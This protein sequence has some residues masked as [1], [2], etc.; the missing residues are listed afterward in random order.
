MEKKL[1]AEIASMMH[2][3]E[4]CEASSNKE[5]YQRHTE[6][7]ETIERS[8]LP[9]GSGIDNGCTID[10]GRSKQNRIVL[11]LGFHHMNEHGYYDGW[12][13]HDVIV[14]PSLEF[15]F[16]LRITGRDRN[17]I[18]NYLYDV[19]QVC[20]DATFTEYVDGIM[21]DRQAMVSA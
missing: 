5:W 13:Y 12:S 11:S 14:T 7:L 4:N 21:R 16:D 10:L 19:L 2:A 1:Y 8:C 20:L 3:R 15:G 6:R 9:S 18:K 17:D